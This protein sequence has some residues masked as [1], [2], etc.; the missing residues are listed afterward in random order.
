M[1]FAGVRR[2]LRGI[3][4][5]LPGK[6]VSYDAASQTATIQPTVAVETL[7]GVWEVPPPL[8]GV[9]VSQP[10]TATHYLHLTP[11]S[12]DSVVILFYEQDPAQWR[13]SGAESDPP[14]R[15]RHG[16]YPVALLS[17]AT[18]AQAL[19]PPPGATEALLGARGGASVGVSA[20][21]I[22]LGTLAA[23]DPVVLDSKI[24]AAVGA[25]CDAAGLLPT[26]AAGAPMTPVFAAFKA[27][28]AAALIAALKVVAE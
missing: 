8:T 9:R 17:E 12:G 5:A 14:L 27:S 1:L 7:D 26:P 25:A 20:A 15:R 2:G 4:T 11:A 6:I 21:K 22:R 16:F 18:D 3:H 19:A 23:V 10:L 24:K 28:F 13:A